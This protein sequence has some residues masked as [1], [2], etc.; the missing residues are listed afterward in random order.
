MGIDPLRP[1]VGSLRSHFRSRAVHNTQKALMSDIKVFRTSGGTV[2]ELEGRSVAL[3]KSLQTLI[4]KNL[5]VFLGIRFLASEYPTGKTH[6]GRI[7]T[8][9]GQTR[10]DSR[11]PAGHAYRMLG[12]RET[13]L[14]NR[15]SGLPGNRPG[16]RRGEPATTH[17]P[18]MAPARPGRIPN[19]A[20]HTRQEDHESP[21]QEG[22]R[23]SD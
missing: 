11:P 22:R 10:R 21:P 12:R 15:P 6:G 3:E 16:H 20:T 13:I 2:C 7:D 23:R 18:T 17:P 9:A 4:E 19:L 1:S 5:D 14:L 8:L